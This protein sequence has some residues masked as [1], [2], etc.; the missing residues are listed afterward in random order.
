MKKSSIKVG[1][2]EFREHIARYLESEVPVAVTCRGETLGV[3]VPMTRRPKPGTADMDELRAA[4]DRL[5]DELR[6]VSEEEL[7]EDFKQLRRR[8]KKV[9]RASSSL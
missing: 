9:A 1:V 5:A 7:I 6:D 2:R 4:A 3:F 8:P